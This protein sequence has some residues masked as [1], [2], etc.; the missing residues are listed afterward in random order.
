MRTKRFII[1]LLVGGITFIM[2]SNSAFAGNV[3]RNRWEGVAIGVAAT[4]LGQALLDHHHDTHYRPAPAPRIV[5]RPP[6]RHERP[7]RA[8]SHRPHKHRKHAR[9]HKVWV[10]PVYKKVWN[11]G[12][13]N[14]R[15]WWVS[16]YWIEKEIRPGYWEKHRT[17][18]A[19]HNR[20]RG[21]G[22]R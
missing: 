1:G 18:T 2:I 6:V 19:K 9:F 17:W 11:P 21:H 14:R 13:Y 22:R 3:Q 20:G 7:Y 8:Y 10:P 16:G 12:H 15:G 5:H 4:L